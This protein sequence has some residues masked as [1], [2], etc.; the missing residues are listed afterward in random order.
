MEQVMKNGIDGYIIIGYTQSYGAGGND[1][2]LIKTNGTGIEQWSKT[3]GGGS[4]EYGDSVQQTSDGGYIITGATQSYGAGKNDV[5]LI[6]TDGTGIEQWNK[7]FGG[8]SNDSGQ[9]V[10]QT[11]DDGYIITVYTE[12]YG[13][14]GADAWLIKTNE[15]GCVS[16]TYG[17]LTS[18]NLLAGQ[19]GGKIENFTYRASIPPGTEIKIQFSQNMIEWYSLNG[20][21]NYWDGLSDGNNSFSLVQLNW[22]GSNFYYRMAFTSDNFGAP[23][24][25]NINLSYSQYLPIGT[26]ESQPFDAGAGVNWKTIIWTKSQPSDDI[27]FQLRSAADLISLNLSIFVGPDGTISTYYNTSGD[28]IWTDHNSDQ[29][30]QYKAYLRTTDGNY[31][32]ALED[33]TII[34][35]HLPVVT[36]LVN[37]ADNSLINDSTPMFNWNFFDQDGTQGGFQVLIDDDSGFM[38][39]NYDSGQQS[40]SNQYWQFPTGTGYTTISDGTW[41]WKVKTQDNDGDWGPN[42]S[43]YIVT[44]DATPPNAFT[45]TANPSSWT[46]NTQPEI[47]FSTTDTTSGIDHYEVK[48][49]SGSFSIQTSPCTLSPQMD[50]T[51]IVTVRAYDLAGN[52]QEGTVNVYI[53]TTP[54]NTFTPT[55]N[56][57]SWTTNTQPVITFSTTDTPSGID[58][59]DVKVDSGSFLTQTSPYTLPPQTDGTRTVTVRAYD[60]AGN[61]Q[62]GTVDVFID[63][64]P[65]NAFTPTANPSSWTTNTQPEITFSTTDATSG[66]DHYEVKV[67]SGTFSTQTSPYT[68]PSQMDGTHIVTV[69]AYDQAGNYQEGTV[70][71]YIDT[72]PPNA[73]SLTA[74]PSSWTTNTQPEIMFSTTDATSGVDHYE[75]KV[76][77][78]TFSTQTSPYT[79]S[80]QTEGTHIVIVRAYDL[81]GNYREET[82]NVYIDTLPPNAFTP[83]ANPSSWTTNTQPMISFSTTDGTSGIDYYEVKVDSGSFST[84]TSPYTLSPQTDGMHTVTV[85]AYDKAGNYQDGTVDVFIDTTPPNAFTP[86]ANPSSWTTNTQPMISFSTTDVTSV[87]DH[88][89]VKVESDSFSTQTSPYS[90]PSQSDGMHTVTVRAYDLAGNHWDGTVN[91]YIDT[92]PPNS[93]TP[94]AHPSSWTTN[95]QP[96]V[97]FSTSDIQSG[98][99]HYE[100]KVDS[101]TFSTQTSPYTLP[102][103]TDGTHTV[104]VKVYDK[105]GNTIE[106]IVNVYIDT[107]VPSIIH[108]PVTDGIFSGVGNVILRYKKPDESTY[109]E[110]QMTLDGGTYSAEIPGTV[111]ILEGIYGYYIKAIDKADIPN[112]AY[113]GMLGQNDTEPNALNDIDIPVTRYDTISPSIESM[114]PIG[115]NVPINITIK[116]TFSEAMD[117]NS[118]ENAFSISASVSGIFDWDGNILTFIPSMN[119]NYGTEYTITIGSGA[120]DLAGNNL[121]SSSWKFTTIS[122]DIVGAGVEEYEPKGADIPVNNIEIRILFIQNMNRRPTEEAFSIDPYVDFVPTWF[123]RTLIITPTESLEYNTKYTATISVNATNVNGEHLAQKHEWYFFTEKEPEDEGTSFWETWEPIITALTILMSII[124]FLVGTLTVRKKRGKLRLYLEKID[125]TYNEYKKNYQECEKEL[126]TLRESI[127]K[128]VKRGKLVD[129]HFLI[130]DKKIDEYM[131]EMKAQK[132]GFEKVEPKEE[133]T[134]TGEGSVGD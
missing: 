41:Y 52:Y 62:D 84:K 87:V 67:D 85:R 49:D 118:T 24:I 59:Y 101:G 34:Y 46:T 44:I 6:K 75:V 29:W 47:T 50:G 56:P 126:I 23:S 116:V 20:T 61:Y 74:N 132:N 93:F 122:A 90:L 114:S 10:Q 112:I 117:H 131:Q 76:D 28:N 98:I 78:G 82:V 134:E 94:T 54:P 26:L 83:T 64:M 42:S 86:T 97:V 17:E 127:K 129:S 13:A 108:T 120:K 89:E 8:G 57:G 79:L 91:I 51:H 7:T 69:R 113:F 71:V 30:I 27:R 14:G 125:E 58:H 106:G 25:Q 16:Y 103:Q 9:S 53:D 38:S 12:S 22:T 107:A 19:V 35:N 21:L 55:A 63:T 39:V 68:L 33:V 66:V 73:F 105:V 5:W 99:D 100:V 130:L 70:N 4:N 11:S 96:E 121:V 1:V 36:S 80:P 72:T 15:S 81:A 2:W 109:I 3:F 115:A 88:Y 110:Q 124:I 43:Y 65:P 40:T 102:P 37:P 111:V 45:P 119:L 60:L 123:G 104:T 18:V 92:I 133:A 95:T 128:D 32:P 77:S 48:A 31:T